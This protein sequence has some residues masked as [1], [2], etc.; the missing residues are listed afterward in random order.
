MIDYTKFLAKHEPCVLAW[1]SGPYVHTADRR[2]R[3]VAPGDHA[4]TTGSRPPALTPGFYLFDVRGR[5]AHVVA[6]AEAPDTSGLPLVRG[7]LVGDRVV[8]TAPRTAGARF[9]SSL[10]ARAPTVALLPEDEP[11]PLSVC[12]AR[13]WHSGELIFESL[14]FD[15]E[16]EE[17]ARLALERGD[18]LADARGVASTLRAAFGLAT[19]LRVAAADGVAVSAGELAPHLPS[20]ATGGATAARALLLR[21][22]EQRAEARERARTRAR[23]ATYAAIRAAAPAPRTARRG[24]DDPSARA[25]EALTSAGASMLSVRSL[26][27]GQLEVAFRFEDERFVSVVHATTLQVIDSGICLSGEDDLVTLES[28]PGVIR[29]AMRTGRLVITRR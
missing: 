20:L 12:R 10:S 27:A 25:E 8:T 14:D 9:T 18:G 23:D 6:P 19:G 5:A 16:A 1:L 29:E 28:L 3:V 11:A 2:L 13:V 7:H 4:Q 26:R 17:D 24:R 22:E 15:G 21:L